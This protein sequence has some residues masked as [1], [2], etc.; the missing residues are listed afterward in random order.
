MALTHREAADRQ[1]DIVASYRAGSTAREVAS[2][3]GL[4]APYV[5][6]LAQRAGVRHWDAASDKVAIHNRELAAAKRARNTNRDATIVRERGDGASL[7]L[8]AEHHGITVERV[9]QVIREARAALASASA[10]NET[11]IRFDTGNG[12]S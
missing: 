11:A 6:T 12:E 3:F 10:S 1:R 2:A 9:R 4:S 7:A 5:Y 8:L